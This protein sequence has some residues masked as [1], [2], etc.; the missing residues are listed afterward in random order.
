MEESNR[1]VF[2][3]IGHQPTVQDK[4]KSSY[5]S[6]CLHCKMFGHEDSHCKKKHSSRHEWRQKGRMWVAWKPSS[7]NLT[8]LKVIDQIVHCQAIQSRGNEVHQSNVRD[9]TEFLKKGELFEMRWTGSNYS[10]TNKTIWSR[11]DRV[12]INSLWYGCFDFTQN[13]YLANSLS[14]RAPMVVKFPNSPK[15]KGRF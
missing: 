11:I 10:W 3:Q 8:I 6:L 7:Y 12:I 13:H 5:A 9:F 4:S 15:P 1:T 2:E 14:D